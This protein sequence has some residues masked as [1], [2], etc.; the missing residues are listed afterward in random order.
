MIVFSLHLMND[1]SFMHTKKM[2]WRLECGV[3]LFAILTLRVF[4]FAEELIRNNYF[5]L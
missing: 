1:T 4:K 3:Y 5:R 2:K